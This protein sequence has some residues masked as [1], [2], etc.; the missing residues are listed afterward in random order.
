LYYEAWVKKYYNSGGN[1]VVNSDE[2]IAFDE[3]L[4]IMNTE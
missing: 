4:D 3:W 2:G 1:N